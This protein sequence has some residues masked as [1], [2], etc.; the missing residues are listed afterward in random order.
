M[1]KI[2][3]V[4]NYLV[5]NYNEFEEMLVRTLIAN[6]ISYV[7]IDNEFHFLDKIYRFYDFE[8][9]YK[10]IVTFIQTKNFE[11]FNNKFNFE[12]C[13]KIGSDDQFISE[14]SVLNPQKKTFEYNRSKIKDIRGNNKKV[15]QMINRKVY[16][17]RL[18]N[19][20]RGN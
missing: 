16:S 2:G 19:V 20:R 11:F 8:L 12:D 18:N 15:N 9:H 17:K 7:K 10:E 4:K 1:E 14:T 5:S 6:G 3:T 13:I